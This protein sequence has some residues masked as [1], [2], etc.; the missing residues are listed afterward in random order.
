M[1]YY[2]IRRLG[3]LTRPYL[4]EEHRPGSP[5]WVTEPAGRYWTR[6]AAEKA[7]QVKEN[8]HR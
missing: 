3:R 5:W 6:R 8:L 4:L 1:R 7:R 2:T